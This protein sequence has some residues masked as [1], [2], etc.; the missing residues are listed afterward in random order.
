MAANEDQVAEDNDELE[1]E[2]DSEDR[3]VSDDDGDGDMGDT[4]VGLNVEEIV[5]KID[6]QSD[7]DRQRAIRKRLDEL[8]EQRLAMQDLDSTY[9]FNMDDD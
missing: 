2:I 5:S 3:M 9:N 1:T 6:T 7:I 4:V 8:Q